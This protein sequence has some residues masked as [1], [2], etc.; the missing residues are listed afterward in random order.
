MNYYERHLGDY[1]RDTAHLSILEHGVYTLLLDRY[2]ATEQPIPEDQAHRVARARS[3]DEKAAV[4][5]VLAEF[6][7]LV[8]EE[9]VRGYR[10]TRADLEIERARVRIAAAQENGRRGGR[11]RKNPLGSDQKPNGFSLGYE[12][13]T[14]QK[15]HQ[16]PDTKHQKGPTTP[17]RSSRSESLPTRE[18]SH[19]RPTAAG[20]AC[21]LMREAGCNDTNPSHPR[22]LEALA[23]GVTPQ[24]LADT[25]REAVAAGK[26]RPFAYAITTARNRHAEAAQP[27]PQGT[28]HANHQRPARLGLADRF[29]PANPDDDAID[30]QAVRV[31]R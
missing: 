21:R 31:H 23:D 26:T 13:E 24:A 3:K 12:N 17:D 18:P 30:G 29:Q 19:D 5:R 16:A 9:N 1:A 22:L 4:D 25:A 2:Y 8:E 7:Q 10:N 27:T 11:P 20:L 15:A 6:F 28:R 14:Q